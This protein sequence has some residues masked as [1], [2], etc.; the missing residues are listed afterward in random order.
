[1]TITGSNGGFHDTEYHR[2]FL[3]V[4]VVVVELTVSNSGFFLDC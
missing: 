3:S 1:M 4:V 2:T